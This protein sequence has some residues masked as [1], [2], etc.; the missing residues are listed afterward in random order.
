MGIDTGIRFAQI[1][2]IRDELA[3]LTSMP[4]SPRHPYA[5]ELVFTAFSGSHQDAIHKGLANTEKLAAHF[6][7]WKIPYLHIDPRDL[8]RSFEKFIRINS[9]SGKG[10]IAY[11]L[12]QEFGIR[13]PRKLLVDFSQHVQAFADRAAREVEAREL[14]DIFRAT[15]SRQDGPVRLVNYWPRPGAED[16]TMI[17]G[18]AHVEYGGRT[19]VLTASAP[20]PIAA[21]VRALAQ[22]PLPFTFSLEEY[23]EDAIGQTADAEAITFVRLVDD[24]KHSCYGIGIGVNIDQAA[25]RA[26]ISAVNGLLAAR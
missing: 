7:G 22:L 26:I 4:V 20:G 8:G 10:G 9:Q 11:V 18:E 12:E 1:E 17:E 14:F 16:P 2:A 6:G 25:V 21:F 5:G 24:R 15:Y 23:E 19:Q 3:A 13:L